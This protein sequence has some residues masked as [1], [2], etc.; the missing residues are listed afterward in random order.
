MGMVLE[1]RQMKVDPSCSDVVSFG[2]GVNSVAMTILLVNE[3]WHG[4]IV[5][6]DTGAEWPETYYYMNYFETQW[7][8]YRNLSITHL[9]PNDEWR[10]LATR[11]PLEQYCIE[12]KI[13]PIAFRRWCTDKWKI[14]PMHKWQVVN[15]IGTRLLGIASEEAHRAKEADDRKYPLV[16]QGIDR[17]GCVQIIVE[18]G[19]EIPHRSSCFFCPFQRLSQWEELWVVH[20]DLYERA[21]FLEHN[22]SE[23][24][25]P[26]PSRLDPRGRWS[27]DG[28]RKKFESGMELTGFEYEYLREFQSCMCG[29]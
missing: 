29:L 24:T 11:K 19:L 20:P 25:F 16:D 1:N 3:G 14:R 13:I 5:F 22:A 9:V 6:A 8:S 26:I 2:G 12:S 4:P 23:R 28:L 15:G 21:I 17:N 10:V 7:L 27:L 18:Q